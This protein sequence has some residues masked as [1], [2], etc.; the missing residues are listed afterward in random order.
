MPVPYVTRNDPEL[1][2]LTYRSDTASCLIPAAKNFHGD[3]NHEIAPEYLWLGLKSV[4]FCETPKNI[5]I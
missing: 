5:D 2:V 3:I 1:A 4:L